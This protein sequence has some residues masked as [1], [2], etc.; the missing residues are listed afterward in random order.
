[1]TATSEPKP[2]DKLSIAVLYWETSPMADAIFQLVADSH[3][4]VLDAR[5]LSMGADLNTL[6]LLL[7][8]NWHQLASFEARFAVLKKHHNLSSLIQRFS[9]RQHSIV[10]LPYIAYIVAPDAADVLSHIANFLLKLKI[11]LHE[12][13]ATAYSAPVTH[14]AMLGISLAFILPAN[15]SIADFRENFLIFCDEHNFEVTI[16]PQKN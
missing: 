7:S 5:L 6:T 4:T 9:L 12:L 16:E 2:M 15:P 8:G 11:E 1:M 3:C 13:A 14:A 10:A